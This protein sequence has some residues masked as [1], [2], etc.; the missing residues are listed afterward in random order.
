MAQLESE[1]NAKWYSVTTNYGPCI[2]NVNWCSVMV[3]LGQA[4]HADIILQSLMN[5]FHLIGAAVALI[6]LD[7]SVSSIDPSLLA[8]DPSPPAPWGW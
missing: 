3:G 1:T 2:A 6:V 5:T 4:S 7:C 8:I